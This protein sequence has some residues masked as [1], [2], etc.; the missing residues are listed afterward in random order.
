MELIQVPKRAQ[1]AVLYGIFGIMRIRKNAKGCLI[2]VR[3]ARSE[4]IIQSFPVSIARELQETSRIL[5]ALRSFVE[6][7]SVPARA[8]AIHEYF[9]LPR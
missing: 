8:L 7:L 6:G 4:Q 3:A 5:R 1:Q 9:S 2:E